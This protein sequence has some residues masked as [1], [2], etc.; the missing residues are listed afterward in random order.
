[1]CNICSATPITSSKRDLII[2]YISNDFHRVLY[3]LQSLRSIYSSC[4]IVILYVKECQIIFEP[5]NFNKTQI[6]TPHIIQY[7][8][9]F[10]QVTN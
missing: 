7:M 8:A 4:S 9:Y 10:N 3:T 1:M 2:S 5:I 6:K